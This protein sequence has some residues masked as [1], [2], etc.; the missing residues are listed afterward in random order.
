MKA[1]LVARGYEE[2]SEVQADSP[3]V[4]KST[5]KTMLAIAGMKG[6]QCKTTDVKTAFL[7]GSQIERDV[8]L[9]PPIE[10]N[11]PN[12]LWKLKKVV[13]GLNDAARYWFF[14]VKKE[15]EQLGC[16]QSKFDPALFFFPADSPSTNG[17]LKVSLLSMS[18]ISFT[19]EQMSS[20]K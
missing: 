4:L 5:L 9:K 8:Y 18:M 17:N 1:R 10:A 16:V 3:T 15:L 12:H 19:V 14:S 7:Q 6:W 11:S 2:H 13:Y 20:I